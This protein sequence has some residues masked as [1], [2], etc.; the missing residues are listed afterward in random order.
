M[1]GY[2]QSYRYF[3]DAADKIRQELTPRDPMEPG[4]A[5]VA[6]EID[7]VEAVSLHV[8]RGDYVTNAG[9]APFHG[10]CSLDY[11]RAAVNHVRARVGAPHLFI[12]SDDHDWARD[13][14][15]F[16]LPTTYVVANPPDR[17]FRDMQLMARC[18]HHITANSSFSWWG[19][20]LNPRHDKIVVAPQAWFADP[21]IDTRDLIPQGWTRL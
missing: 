19:A 20:W 1:E 21:K 10:L 13:N 9:A 5:A 2:W 17:G 4:N 16:D 7:A 11:Y 18:R 6:A 14:L 3:A 12:F 15:R 8:R